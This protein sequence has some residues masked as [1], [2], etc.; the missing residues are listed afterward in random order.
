MKGQFHPINWIQ[1]VTLALA[2][3]VAL[4]TPILYLRI[5]HVQQHQ[6]DAIHAIICRAEHV[7]RIQPDISA[8]RRRE[9]LRFYR[10]AAA[11]AHLKPCP[12]EAKS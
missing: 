2:F 5:Q 12:K 4:T 3:T 9:A 10:Q 6:N 1:W 8:K 11:D 7:V